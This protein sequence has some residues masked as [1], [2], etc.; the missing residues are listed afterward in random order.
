MCLPVGIPGSIHRYKAVYQGSLTDDTDSGEM[1]LL[2]L[3][4]VV[5][6]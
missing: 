1:K 5:Q 6:S 2:V 4:E 3:A